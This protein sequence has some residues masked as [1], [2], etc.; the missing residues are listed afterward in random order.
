[1]YSGYIAG[2]SRSKG[3]DEGKHPH[4]RSLSNGL[5]PL[6]KLCAIADVVPRNYLNTSF[7]LTKVGS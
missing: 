3:Q 2:L 1:M 7:F 6:L 4:D 5:Q